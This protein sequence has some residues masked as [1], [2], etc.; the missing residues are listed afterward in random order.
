[1]LLV[2]LA[3]ALSK[4]VYGLRISEIMFN[5]DGADTGREWIEIE[6]N[7][8]DGCINLTEYKLF[9][10][11]TNHNIY[12]YS[13]E[14]A[15]HYA[16]ICS[17]VNKF[18]LDYEYLNKSAANTDHSS[19]IQIYKSTFSLSNSGEE[20]ALKRNNEFIDYIDYSLI[21]VGV[22]CLG[23]IFYSVFGHK[24]DTTL[25]QDKDRI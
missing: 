8:S 9:E 20:L 22:T 11:N 24:A 4:Q 2:I 25:Q 6:L 14:L 15:C 10:E 5:P 13:D 1:M 16:I 12:A 7:E 19:N 21:L 18:L 17:D 23:I 3:S